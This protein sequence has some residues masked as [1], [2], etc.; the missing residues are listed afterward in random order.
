MA[1]EKKVTTIKTRIKLRYDS[2][3]NWTANDPVL[4][5]GEIA[6]C[7]PGVQADGVDVTVVKVGDGVKKFSEAADLWANAA[8]VPQWIKNLKNKNFGSYL[9]ETGDT[10]GTIAYTFTDKDG[11]AKEKK[12]IKISG[13]DAL[14]SRISTLESK[15]AVKVSVNG[16]NAIAQDDNGIIALTDIA[17][18]AALEGEVTRAKTAEAANTSAITEEVTRAKAAEKENK[19]SIASIVEQIGTLT[20]NITGVFHFKGTV[21]TKADLDSIKDPKEGDVYHVSDTHDEYVYAEIQETGEEA[22]TGKWEV[23]GSLDLSGLEKK[24]N[25]ISDKVTTLE[26]KVGSAED[27]ADA[28]GSLFARITKEVTDRKAADAAIEA[29]L[30]SADGTTIVNKNNVLS[31]GAIAQSQVTGLPDALAK[32]IESVSIKGQA[33]NV[34]DGAATLADGITEAM[35]EETLKA[36]LAKVNKVDDSSLSQSTD[37]TLSIKAVSTDKIIQGEQEFVLD[38]GDSKL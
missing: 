23:L 18:K 38:G 27:P 14:V 25:P 6:I 29:K 21:A 17:S 10:A 33:F 15:P 1:D 35:L 13:W 30:L 4:L 8:D 37:G 32:K 22:K 20:D 26:E 5:K 24:I 34:T 36:K 3:T 28:T 2:L 16:E 31:V 11:A 9:F 7:Y 12:E 19:D